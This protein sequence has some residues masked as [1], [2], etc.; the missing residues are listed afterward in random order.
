[1]DGIKKENFI[2]ELASMSIEEINKLIKEKGKRPK[3]IP[4]IYFMDEE[5]K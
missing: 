3:L 5:D 4:P 1:M 2:K